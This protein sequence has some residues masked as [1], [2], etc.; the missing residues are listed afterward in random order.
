MDQSLCCVF[1][2]VIAGGMFNCSFP[3][4]SLQNWAMKWVQGLEHKTGEERLRDLGGFNLEKRS[5][6]LI[7]SMS[8]TGRCSEVGVRLFSDK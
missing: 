8:L 1:A 3:E 6:I 5:S 2:V 4:T 7:L